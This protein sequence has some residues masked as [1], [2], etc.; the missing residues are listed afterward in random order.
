MRKL[1]TTLMLIA[2][3]F[4][5]SQRPQGAGGFSMQN[6][7]QHIGV[8]SGKL[9]DSKNNDP[10]SFANVRLFRFNDVLLEGTITDENGGFEFKD[11]AL[12]NGYILI[13]YMGYEEKKV[14]TTLNRNKKVE[15]LGK[16]KVK[17]T[18]VKLEEVSINEDRPIYETKMEKI[19]YNA[20]N[21]LN[22]GLD[23]AADVLRKAPLLSVDLEGNVSLRGSQNIKFLVNGKES[24]F[25]SGSA[26]EALQ[27]IP[28][29]Q[30]KS[31]EVITSPTAKYDGEGGAGIINIIT[32]QKQISG[33]KAT[34]NGSIGTR[35]NKQSLSLNYGKGK[36][37]FSARARVRYGWPLGG[38]Q[39]YHRFDYIDNNTLTKNA[40]TKGQW[41]GFGGSSEMYYD[42]NPYNSIITSIQLRGNRRTN[43]EW[44]SDSLY[45]SILGD[46][47]LENIAYAVNDTTRYSDLI[48][49]MAAY[50][51]TTDYIKKFSRH[52]DQELRIAFQLGGDF[53]DLDN[54][55]ITNPNNP[56][57]SQ[58]I[59]NKNDGTPLTYT[60][61]LDY[62]YP[63]KDKH[64][65]ELGG[66]FVNRNLINDY[67]T[68]IGDT[69][70]QPYE[71]FDY[72]QSLLALYA[73]SS[74]E[75][76]KKWSAV[77][78]L[79]MENTKISGQWNSQEDGFWN[80]NEKGSIKPSPYTNYLPS[81]I[82]S[83]KIDR[84]TSLKLSY[85]KRISRPGMRYINP[86]TSYND[87]FSREEGNPELTPE[88]T[89]Q[90]ELGY[91]S[92]AK[93]YKAS[94]YLFGKMTDDLIESRT[95]VL[96]GI[97][98]T[99]YSNTGNKFSVGI[100]Y[101]GSYSLKNG[102]VRAGFN[103]YT[104]NTTEN[105]LGD[106][107]FNWNIGGNYDLG[108]GYKAETFGFFR[109]RNQTS[110]GYTP[111]FSMFSIGF[112]KELNNKKGSIG[113]RF[114]EPF[115]KYKSFETELEEDGDF[116]LYSNRN[117]VFRSI[118]IS[119]KYTFGELKFNAIKNRTNIRNDDMKSQDGGEGEF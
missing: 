66:K 21:D 117:V 69:Y 98:I 96:D 58:T 119:F 42:I 91:N 101:F 62:I 43:T 1:I 33:F 63:I 56:N 12:A 53:S 36:F 95:L 111:G 64:K 18:S 54:T 55:V 81:F 17:K 74:L 11:L 79:R 89:H 108:K 10:L 102:T 59:L 80:I 109:K 20:E 15:F 110:Q 112:K 22:E 87:G 49:K 88:K 106:I 115:K 61:Q 28:A 99:S 77:L 45:E 34:V 9:V 27:M 76:S 5:F 50:E 4:L 52:E 24:T 68:K 51:W 19:V 60:Y 37:G 105:D 104:Y 73:S 29:E 30:V 114:I 32:Q 65:I 57:L 85:S 31:V 83:R 72:N 13:N 2:P 39:T 67:S 100:N 71:Q 97:D 26:S 75:L 103:L 23:D 93:K 46:T 118:G 38:S 6:G 84:A 48:N 41:I 47:F 107:L 8:V 116:Y 7:S 90:L 14:E 70:S 94:Y 44:A 40:Q 78:G 92:F 86:N 16:I 3:L 82:L 113:I 25:F 35:V